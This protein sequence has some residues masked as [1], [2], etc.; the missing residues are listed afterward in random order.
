MTLTCSS[1]YGF[2]ETPGFTHCFF[3]CVCFERKAELRGPWVVRKEEAIWLDWGVEK[4]RRW[5]RWCGAQVCPRLSAP[6]KAFVIP[7]GISRC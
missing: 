5:E 4:T 1:L 2:T 6:L 7:T 3:I